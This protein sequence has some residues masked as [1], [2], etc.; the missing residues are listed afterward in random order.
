[1]ASALSLIGALW[2][3]KPLRWALA[4]FLGW[5]SYEVWKHHQRSI[6]ASQVVEKIE[7]KANEDAKVADAAAESVAAGKPGRPDPFRVRK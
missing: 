4:A 7:R 5:G 1:M 3:S 6:G 2:G